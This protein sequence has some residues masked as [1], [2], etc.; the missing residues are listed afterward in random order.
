MTKKEQV[1][2]L[3]QSGKS[4]RDIAKEL[5]ISE[6]TV[7]NYE[8]QMRQADSG[9]EKFP[10]GWNKKRNG[11]RKCMYRGS[12]SKQYAQNPGCNYILMAGHSRGCKVED[13]TVFRKG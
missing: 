9:K 5:Y 1:I 12:K 4:T 10:A 11:C 2:K 8:S 3:R 13:C 6:Q 7:R